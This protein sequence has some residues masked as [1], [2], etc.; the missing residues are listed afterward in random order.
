MSDWL[1]YVEFAAADALAYA[2]CPS[3]GDG[4]FLDREEHTGI[5]YT[6]YCCGNGTFSFRNY[7]VEFDV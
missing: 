4:W 2:S 3:C 7:E 6:C 1:E 5:P